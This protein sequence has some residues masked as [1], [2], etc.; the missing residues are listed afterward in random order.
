MSI[1]DVNFWEKYPDAEAVGVF[2]ELRTKRGPQ[3]SSDIL[4]TIHCMMDP[5]NE[6]MQHLPPKER[7]EELKKFYNITDKD[8][9]SPLFKRSVEWYRRN[10]MSA[11]RRYLNSLREKLF[12]AQE[13]IETFQVNSPDDIMMLSEIQK[14]FEVFKKGHDEAEASFRAEGPVKKKLGGDPLG[15]GDD[16]SIFDKL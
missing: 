11:P 15:A 13:H 7:L 2:R 5:T 10:W 4:W 1:V 8:V 6:F 16:G 9:E 3:K 12:A 14:A